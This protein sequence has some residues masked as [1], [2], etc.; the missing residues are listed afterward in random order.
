MYATATVHAPSGN[1]AQRWVETVVVEMARRVKTITA[2]LAVFFP[3]AN[4]ASAA[5][6]LR[7]TLGAFLAVVRRTAKCTTFI[8]GFTKVSETRGDVVAAHIAIPSRISTA[9]GRVFCR[10]WTIFV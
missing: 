2:T 7:T 10:F 3:A 5:F 9:V 6:S 8:I 4:F 1:T